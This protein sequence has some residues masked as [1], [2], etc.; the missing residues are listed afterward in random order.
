[1]SVYNIDRIYGRLTPCAPPPIPVDSAP[2][3]G[4]M[5]RR[6]HSQSQPCLSERADKGGGE[7]KIKGVETREVLFLDGTADRGGGEE[8]IKT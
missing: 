3:S 8:R 5:R 2:G 4:T 7:E 1:M 6:V